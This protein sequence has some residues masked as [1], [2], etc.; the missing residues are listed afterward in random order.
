MKHRHLPGWV[1]P[2]IGAGIG[3][4]V[5]LR[6]AEH[7]QPG[8]PWPLL[9]GGAAVGL[10]GGLFVWMANRSAGPTPSLPPMHARPPA[11]SAPDNI[12]SQ[13]QH[14]SVLPAVVAQLALLLCW[15]P[16]VGLVLAA[17]AMWLNRNREGYPR[18]ISRIA[19]A[20]ASVF[21][22]IALVG[23]TFAFWETDAFWKTNH[24]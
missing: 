3:A 20:V 14:Q 5:G 7:P 21:T 18:K 2:W 13:A 11:S 9:L 4:A 16:Y 22:A 23:L 6:V 8:S 19:F 1:A 17:V 10:V 15:T 24:P 12:Q